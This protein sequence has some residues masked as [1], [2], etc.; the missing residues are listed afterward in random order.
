[1]FL[2]TNVTCKQFHMSGSINNP[3]IISKLDSQ[4]TRNRVYMLMLL[5][6]YENALTKCDDFFMKMTSG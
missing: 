1:M 5:M 3:K 4:G 2:L 6:F